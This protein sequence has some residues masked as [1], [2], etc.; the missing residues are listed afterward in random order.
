MALSHRGEIRERQASNGAQ[1]TTVETQAQ[2]ES[3]QSTSAYELAIVHRHM[4]TY[5]I[6]LSAVVAAAS[7]LMR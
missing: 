4:L 6:G 2:G 3:S 5:R 7:F 1:Q